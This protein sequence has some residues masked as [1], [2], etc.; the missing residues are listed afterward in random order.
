MSDAPEFQMMDATGGQPVMIPQFY[1]SGMAC[2]GTPTDISVIFNQ[3]RPVQIQKDGKLEFIAAAM[4][5]AQI[6][7]SPQTAK[8][9]ML[10]LQGVMAGY[11]VRFGKLTTE[12]SL[13]QTSQ[14]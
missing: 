9:L 10:I 12:Y 2:I 1:A 7:M 3:G 4:P 14:K 11:E 5:V 6:S 13:K 8:D